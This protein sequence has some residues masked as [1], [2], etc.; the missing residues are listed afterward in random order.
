MSKQLASRSILPRSLI[1]LCDDPALPALLQALTPE[2][3]AQLCT[4]VGIRDAGPLMALAPVQQRVQALAV[5][6]WKRPRPGVA[7]VFDPRELMDWLATW[8][9]ESEDL[10]AESFARMPEEDLLLY[11][12]HVLSVATVKMWGLERST[13]MEDLDRIYAPSY[14]ESAYGPYMVTARS[15]EHWQTLREALDAWWGLEPERM[16]TVLSQLVGDESMRAPDQGRESSNRDFASG[17]EHVQERRGHVSAAGAR[18]FLSFSDTCSME[19]IVALREFD[20]ETRRH[21]EVFQ[22]GEEAQGMEPG[23]RDGVEDEEEARMQASASPPVSSTTLDA[24]RAGL[25]AEG[26]LDAPPPRL[27]THSGGEHALPLVTALVKLSAAEP[28]ALDSRGLEL[29]YLANVLL[30][31][32]ALQD[33]AMSPVEA[34][35]AALALCNLGYELLQE[36]R[37]DPRLGDPEP[38]LVRLFLI[39]RA[40]LRDVPGQ[41]VQAFGQAL[42]RLK[43]AGSGPAHEWR[44]AEA[45]AAFED[46]R[47]AVARHERVAAREALDLMGFFFEHRSCQQAAALLDEIPRLSQGDGNGALQWLASLQDLRAL[48]RLLGS[49]GVRGH[50]G[51]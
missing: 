13:E 45:Q 43:A 44:V 17:R 2:A 34:R 7:E 30:A 24:I 47:V 16:L 6:V 10:A 51:S 29:A 49:I 38:G 33:A 11:L 20:L 12:S 8:L 25:E 1:A 5:S 31:G 22:S 26:L 27:L 21:L 39:G 32:V 14:H 36:R 23:C 15:G 42:E 41:V 48:D 35:E 46:L 4:R 9:E 50:G 28:A 3:L 19:K 40:A 18:A 37:E